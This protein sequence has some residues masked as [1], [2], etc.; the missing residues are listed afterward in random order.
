[1]TAALKETLPQA[2]VFLGPDA[3]RSI[4]WLATHL[5]TTDLLC[6]DHDLDSPAEDP[7]HDPGDGR[8]VV[9]WLIAQPLRAPVL[10]HTS[11]GPCGGQMH[12]LL[13]DAG[14]QVDWTPPYDDLVWVRRSWIRRVGEMLAGS[15]RG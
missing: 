4:A 5:A 6:L 9:R 11:N 13:Q 10:I 8:E 14:W 3:H 1:M 2:T 15:F 7:R 12:W